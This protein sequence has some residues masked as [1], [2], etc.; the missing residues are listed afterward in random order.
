MSKLYGSGHLVT[1]EI[2]RSD[3]LYFLTDDKPYETP[4]V[5]P[6]TEIDPKA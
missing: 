6:W 5:L 4:L 2:I 3:D 1:H